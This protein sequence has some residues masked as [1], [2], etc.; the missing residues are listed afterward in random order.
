VVI[1]NAANEPERGGTELRPED[2]WLG[3][4]PVC[5]T[6]VLIDDELVRRRRRVVHKECAFFRLRRRMLFRSAR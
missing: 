6:S 4:C 1:L 5:G 2:A 3:Q